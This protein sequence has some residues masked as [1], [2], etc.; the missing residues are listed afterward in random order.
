MDEGSDDVCR[1]S[2]AFLI[3]HG[4]DGDGVSTD[5]MLEVTDV[6]GPNLTVAILSKSK[7]L[8]EKMNTVYRS[9]SGMQLRMRFNSDTDGIFVVHTEAPL[10]R[11]ALD[12]YIASMEF[13]ELKEFKKR[14]KVL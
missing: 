6:I 5:A 1:Y 14:S 8:D 3:R 2:Y 7:E 4:I 10:T 9:L 12:N 13:N 11:E